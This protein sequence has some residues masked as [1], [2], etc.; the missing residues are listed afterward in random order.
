MAAF[1]CAA[2]LLT[3]FVGFVWFW[4][5]WRDWHLTPFLD[6]WPARFQSTVEG[7]R[8]L[9][10]GAFAGWRWAMLGG[11]AIAT[12]LTQSLTVVA[13]LPMIVFGNQIGYH[14]T[15]LLLF[16]AVPALVLWDLSRTEKQTFSFVAAAFVAL[17][18]TAAA[19]NFMR[20]GDTNAMTGLAG[21]TAVLAA[22]HHAST[23]GRYGFALLVAALTITAYSNLSYVPYA[24]A[25]LVLEAIYYRDLRRLT[26]AGAAAI[27]AALAS[28]P[29]TYE[30]LRYPSE[31][32]VN[33]MSFQPESGVNIGRAARKIFY[34]F[35]ILFEPWRWLNDA[36]GIASMFLPLI[37]VAAWRREGRGGYYAWAALFA[38]VLFRLSI[39]EAGATLF[40]S[41]HLLIVFAPVAVAWFI[42]ARVWDRWLAVALM[43]LTAICFQITRIEVPHD[44]SVSSFLPALTERIRRI[45]DVRVLVE[46]NPHRDT[47]ASPQSRSEP[48][49]YG[50]HYEALLPDA[51]GKQF[52][53][54]FWD[55]W[56]FTPHNGEMLAGGAWQRHLLTNDDRAPFIEEMRRWGVRHLFVW[57]QTATTQ[58]SAWPEFQKTWEAEPWR[59]YVLREPFADPR[60]IETPHGGGDLASL[61]PF[62]GTVRLSDVRSGD[63][64]VVRT[65][66]HPAWQ[67]AAAGRPLEATNQNGQLSFT[68][69]ADGSY[70]VSLI[71]PARRWL[72]WFP[73][74]VIVLLAVIHSRARP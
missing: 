38:H 4:M 15:H 37:L 39:D 68:A 59:E 73:A 36:I 67:I 50:I 28:L 64:V 43:A 9:H 44:V 19:W 14:L 32:V 42:V 18:M 12:D 60:M 11:Y 6:D 24:L 58:L 31:F 61:T 8:L 10:Q 21:V 26:R 52:Y 34:N 3:L 25:L 13:A 63:R 69:P 47:D 16:L 40:R 62:G 35:Q 70:D 7:L 66:F 65:H 45:D 71:Y 46:N 30:L 54:G 2:A 1:A 29:A 20:S 72:L 53:A 17:S 23:R 27:L 33:N 22:S 57:S 74:L 56:Q 48:S 49:L 41:F 51:T 55:G 5:P